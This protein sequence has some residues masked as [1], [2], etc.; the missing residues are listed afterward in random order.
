MAA[1]PA[2][3][4]HSLQGLLHLGRQD[5][6]LLDHKWFETLLVLS[7]LASTVDLMIELSVNVAQQG[8]FVTHARDG[9][10]VKAVTIV[11]KHPRNSEHDFGR[12]E[13][14]AVFWHAIC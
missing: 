8:F 14:H 2:L 13:K 3:P 10:W 5:A 11:L 7:P 4:A 6:V 1:V 12:K 9:F